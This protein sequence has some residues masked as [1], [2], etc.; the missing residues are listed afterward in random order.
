MMFNLKNNGLRPWGP[1]FCLHQVNQPLPF[2]YVIIHFFFLLFFGH[3]CLFVFDMG[4]SYARGQPKIV[5]AS[6]LICDDVIIIV[7]CLFDENDIINNN[8]WWR[9]C[10]IFFLCTFKAKCTLGWE[11]MHQKI[12]FHP[13]VHFHAKSLTCL[14]FFF[15]IHFSNCFPT[16]PFFAFFHYAEIYTFIILFG[17]SVEKPTLFKKLDIEAT[18]AWVAKPSTTWRKSY[19]VLEE[20][21]NYVKGE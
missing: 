12:I 7:S 9:P 4:K 14:F 8:K 5:I 19:V 20:G 3:L 6:S 16:T 18:S 17:L 1:L 15:C 2:A 13:K 10:K 11:K 21:K